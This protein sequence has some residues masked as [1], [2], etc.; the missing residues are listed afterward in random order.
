VGT[1]V[2]FWIFEVGGKFI[3]IAKRG[4]LLYCNT[5]P[6]GSEGEAEE[7]LASNCRG[8]WGA[9]RMVRGR[10][11]DEAL[12]REIYSLYSGEPRSSLRVN[13]AIHPNKRFQ[14]A[15]KM[16]SLI[17]RGVFTTYGELARALNTSPRVIGSYA[18]RNPY[19]LLI[20]C[21][22]IVRGDMGVGGYGYG[23][24]LKARLLMMEGV[25]VD[26]KSMR[27]NPDKLIRAEG[28]IALGR[29]VH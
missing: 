26:L 5:I 12:A 18:A 16:M 17:P 22:R 13:F 21:H 29:C 15:L 23:T 20:P 14:D 9:L 28:L 25:E 24:E 8:A 3:G 2:V 11:E 1:E 10:I 6:L 19:P 4:E 27:V 7:D